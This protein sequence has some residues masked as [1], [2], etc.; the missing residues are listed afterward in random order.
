MTSNLKFGILGAGSIGTYIGAHLIRA[1]LDTVLVGRKKLAHEIQENGLRITNYRGT[2]F[3]LALQ[4]VK[5][6][7]EI[8][9]LAGRDIV[10]VTVK[11]AA[12]EE[13]VTR[14]K[15]VLP[16]GKTVVSFQNGVRNAE[17]LRSILTEAH[18]LAGMVPYNVVWNSPAHFH[19]GTSGTLVIEEQGNISHTV[20][21]GLRQA[22][23]M[24]KTH[25]D[26]SGI[27][28]G[29]LIFNL[30]NAINALAGIPLREEI[31]DLG[32][33][34]IIAAAMREALMVLKQSRIRPTGS[35]GM[36]PNVAPFI[37]S[38][39]NFLFLRVASRMIQID[40]QARSSMWQD[41]QQGKKTEIDFI[42]GEIVTLAQKNGL[43]APIN[44]KVTTLIKEVEMKGGGS[45][46]ISATE[47][48][49]KF[50][51]KSAH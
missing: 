45:P 16:A 48:L 26:L 47:M 34:K 37:L 35:G 40:P 8:E 43:A 11:S 6:S 42:N 50:S 41:L 27:L 13:S 20:L 36:Q 18:V 22:G 2:D 31:S 10:L 3:H 49:K 29:K 28:W 33:R 39:P 21:S 25:A 1:G 51:I 23:L 32:Y 7:T 5:Y 46:N 24:A 4:Q 14:L 38:L 17:V 19:C 44:D 30:N 9:S 12:T 15:P